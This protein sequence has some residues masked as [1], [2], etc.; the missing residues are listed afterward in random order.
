ML[1]SQCGDMETKTAV[2]A[3][4]IVSLRRIHFLSLSIVGYN[5]EV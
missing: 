1:D 5:N 4:D 2:F 3:F